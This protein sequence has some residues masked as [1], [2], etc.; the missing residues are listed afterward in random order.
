MHLH[1]SSILVRARKSLS[2]KITIFIVY[3]VKNCKIN[4][5]IPS[6]LH[7]WVILHS[8]KYY[9]NIDKKNIILIVF[10]ENI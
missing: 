5:S 9:F 2:Y 3:W 10:K 6:R 8:P 1:S 4:K 7:V